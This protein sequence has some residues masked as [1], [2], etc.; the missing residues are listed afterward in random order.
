MTDVKRHLLEALDLE[1][2]GPTDVAA[3]FTAAD[4]RAFLR[5]RGLATGGRKSELALRLVRAM[6]ADR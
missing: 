4:F 1:A 3:R 5:E 2:L 6:K